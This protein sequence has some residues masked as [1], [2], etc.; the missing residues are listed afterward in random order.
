MSRAHRT[1]QGWI[2]EVGHRPELSK[3]MKRLLLTVADA[4]YVSRKRNE[5]CITQVE[6]ARRLD[7]NVSNVKRATWEALDLG[8]LVL[9]QSGHNG[10]QQRFHRSVPWDPPRYWSRTPCE[11]CG[12]WPTVRRAVLVHQAEESTGYVVDP[13]TG[14]LL[15]VEGLTVGVRNAPLEDGSVGVQNAPLD[16]T[17]TRTPYVC[18]NGTS[19]RDP[20][21]I[22]LA[23]DIAAAVRE[24]S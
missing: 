5:Y 10:R 18:S 2:D 12:G 7:V 11:R 14:E 23:D 8:W 20:R 19:S 9:C 1:H 16:R 3:K 21:Y 15:E 13:D 4:T 6:L 22:A 17:P 24:A